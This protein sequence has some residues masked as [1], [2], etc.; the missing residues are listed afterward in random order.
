DALI[1]H[2]PVAF[3]VTY[4]IGMVGATWFLSQLAPK[5]LRIDLAEECRKLEEKMQGPAQSSGEPNATA[6]RRFEF[7]SYLLLDGSPL[8]GH[9]VS[10]VEKS[11]PAERYFIERIRNGAAVMEADPS[12]LLTAGEVIA[13]SGR[14]EVLAEKLDPAKLGLREVDDKEL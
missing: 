14:R 3:A 5:I 10:E 8:I 4:L 1:N 9:H 7:R 11:D 6:R 12:T 2:I 13:V